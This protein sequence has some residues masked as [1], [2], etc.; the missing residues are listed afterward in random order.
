M[1]TAPNTRPQ[2]K[3][4]ANRVTVTS[5]PSLDAARAESLEPFW[6]TVHRIAQRLCSDSAIA[7]PSA[8]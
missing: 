6:D 3:P 7:T 8:A 4:R 5:L 1:R 2:P